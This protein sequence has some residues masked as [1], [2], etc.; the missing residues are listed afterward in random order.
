M[1][2]IVIRLEDAH[3][4]LEASEGATVPAAKA[5]CVPLHRLMTFISEHAE[6]QAIVRNRDYELI[7][8]AR[9][10]LLEVM[11]DP[12]IKP[13]QKVVDAKWILTNAASD[14]FSP[15]AQVD[16]NAKPKRTEEELLEIIRSNR[17]ILKEALEDVAN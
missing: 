17:D 9:G 5:L 11:R 12:D 6:L 3:A 4:A 7:D 1:H 10:T 16:T 2:N 14:V 13:A 8:L 15:R